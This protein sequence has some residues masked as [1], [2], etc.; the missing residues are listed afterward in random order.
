MDSKKSQT[1]PTTT[2]GTCW[3]ISEIPSNNAHWLLST[4]GSEGRPCT[5]QELNPGPHFAPC[6]ALA[7]P[8][9]IQRQNLLGGG[10]QRQPQAKPC[11]QNAVHTVVPELRTYAN[12]DH[13]SSQGTVPI[14]GRC[15]PGA[16]D[17]RDPTC[18]AL[19]PLS[20]AQAPPPLCDIPSPPP[21]PSL[22]PAPPPSFPYPTISVPA[23]PV[24]H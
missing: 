12:G 6:L 17:Q 14:E 7:S 1:T 8:C 23:F 24:S 10:G 3:G 20:P 4:M 22:S 21:P 9:T 11:G 2:G 19:C 13:S 18:H 16:E 5:A 15:G